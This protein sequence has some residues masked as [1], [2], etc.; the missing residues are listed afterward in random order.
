MHPIP[1]KNCCTCLYFILL[2]IA[3]INSE[4][5]HYDSI[6]LT[7]EGKDSSE[8]KC[9]LSQSQVKKSSILSQLI[10]QFDQDTGKITFDPDVE[11]HEHGLFVND[12]VLTYS[13]PVKE[14][15]YLQ[16]FKFDRA[17]NDMCNYL[18]NVDFNQQYHHELPMPLFLNNSNDFYRLTQLTI[19]EILFMKQIESFDNNNDSNISVLNINMTR[20]NNV[21]KIAEFLR[22]ERLITIIAG[23]HAS[24]MKNMTQQEMIKW[25]ID[26][27]YSN[28]NENAK[29]QCFNRDNNDNG[30]DLKCTI[31]TDVLNEY[32]F[33]L[34]NE[35]LS[36]FSCQDVRTFASISQ[37]CYQIADELD[38]IKLNI[39]S[40]IKILTN[41]N[42]ATCLSLTNQ[43]VLFYR[44]FLALP[45]TMW[46]DNQNNIYNQLKTMTN[47]AINDGLAFN[48]LKSSYEIVRLQFEITRSK[49]DNSS[50][51]NVVS[52][53]HSFSSI[54]FK[55]GKF[56]QKLNNLAQSRKIKR[57]KIE[58]D[59]SQFLSSF[60]DV[61]GINDI[62]NIKEI[63]INLHSFLNIDFEGM[64]NLNQVEYLSVTVLDDAT[65]LSIKNDTCFDFTFL[66]S[67]PSLRVLYL[68][69]NHIKCI[70]NMMAFQGTNI[71]DIHL[72]GNQLNHFSDGDHHDLSSHVQPCLDFD[73][74]NNMQQLQL[75]DLGYNNIQ[76]IINFESLQQL[77]QL[78][79]LTLHE[80]HLLTSTID[81]TKFDESKPKLQSLRLVDLG[82]MNLKYT[83]SNSNNNNNNCFDLQFLRFMPN[84]ES[85]RLSN[86]KIECMHNL[87][88]LKTAHLKLHSLYLRNNK[89]L[90]FDFADL[91]GS[92]VNAIDL[93]A[94]SLSF[95]ELKHVDNNTV[96]RIIP[97]GRFTLTL[98]WGSDF[99]L[100]Q[101]L[102][103]LRLRNVEIAYSRSH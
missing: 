85:L 92:N 94:N 81:F 21:F 64:H 49:Y 2:S 11:N 71:Q 47:N 59:G 9:V 3:I 15:E 30:G 56:A 55:F 62:N 63:Q 1:V 73:S 74:F 91:I 61:I 41:D 34:L 10:D 33:V 39:D 101:K 95:E 52:R 20:M 28:P 75:L 54:S 88:I 57:I 35:I 99:K 13:I 78:K 82:H 76:C 25:L 42:D 14:R 7:L 26:I 90:S 87:T 70:V 18:Q 100:G 46:S 66:N 65:I 44:P 53:Y 50:I 68:A 86:N 58:I 12:S 31:N 29:T 98:D 24:L 79:E 51:I 102:Y 6:T 45:Q 97:S 16:F 77:T 60:N 37:S 4:L 80:N 22:I 38:S 8:Y 84:V 48:S 5:Q 23:R 19:Q 103:G 17:F 96:S 43:E 67:A 32:N 83:S 27:K 40:M 72:I 36:F 89:L 69:S 93:G